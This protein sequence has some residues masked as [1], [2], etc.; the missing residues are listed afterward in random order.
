MVLLT[1]APK[2]MRYSRQEAEAKLAWNNNH[3]ETQKFMLRVVFLPHYETHKLATLPI[4]L[5]ML[6]SI[7]VSAVG[8]ISKMDDC[9]DGHE[10]VT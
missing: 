5:C 4:E 3:H 6:Q 1:K 9:N 8:G 7:W 2:A 10:E